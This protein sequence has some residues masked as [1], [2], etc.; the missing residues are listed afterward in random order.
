MV[1]KYLILASTVLAD[2]FLENMDLFE[3]IC[4]NVKDKSLEKAM[5]DT[6]NNPYYIPGKWVMTCTQKVGQRTVVLTNGVIELL[7]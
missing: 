7:D 2:S 5:K 3:A 4:E 1:I 6:E